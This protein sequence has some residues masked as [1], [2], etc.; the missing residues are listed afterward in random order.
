[1]S[2]FAGIGGGYDYS[3]RTPPWA[4]WIHEMAHDWGLDGHAPG[5]GWN[6]GIMTN[7]GGV[8]LALN[9]WDRFLLTWMPDELVFCETKD[10]LQ[11]TSIKL[12]ALERDDSQT[13]MVA[14]ALDNHRLLVVEAHGIGKWFSRRPEQASV[15][16]INFGDTGL[17]YLLAYIVDTKF[18][19]PAQTIVNSDGS[20]L[21]IDDG[22]NPNI[23]R[24][25][26]LQKVLGETGSNDYRLIPGS[27]KDYGA[28]LAVQGDSFSIEGINIEFI[29]TGDFETI[30]ISKG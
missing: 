11:T 24:H 14:V 29:S 6:I 30:K 3:V 12:S 28:Y 4:I 1:M 15:F 25:A 21:Q 16:K 27:E 10:T 2:L 26:Y 20:A 9:A 19:Y 8:S 22:V 17:Y 18:I 13:K 7:Q 5:N 23:P